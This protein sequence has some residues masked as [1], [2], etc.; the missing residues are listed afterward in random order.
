MNQVYLIGAMTRDPELR[1]TPSGVPIYEGTI[2][3]EDNITDA[4][5]VKRILPWYHRFSMIGKPAEWQAERGLARGMPVFIEGSL[6][7][8]QWETPENA[9]RSAVKV[10]ALR[11][12]GLTGA[13]DQYQIREDASGGVRLV[14][15]MNEVMLIGNTGRNMELR[16]ITTGDAVA[17][18]NIAVNESWVDRNGQRQEKT[19]W[20]ALSLWRELATTHGSLV[21]GTPVQVKGRLINQSW[22]DK[23]GNKRNETRVEVSMMHA[24]AR[25]PQGEGA[26]D[27]E[28][29]VRNAP[30]TPVPGRGGTAARSDQP[31]PSAV[32][33]SMASSAA[34]SA[35]PSAARGNRPMPQ[36]ADMDEFP[37]EEDL[38][39]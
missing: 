4:Q 29:Q 33:S 30:T 10:K 15:G 38:P 12:E 8:S 20:I 3:G 37:P 2:A 24:L 19:H 35:G 5:G 23:E 16:S 17:S 36:A 11:I 21:G 27:G 1:Y 18:T 13:P 9:K 32:P 22:T 7:Y 39:F 31:A 25:A 14:G 26:R 28:G 6:D 34:T